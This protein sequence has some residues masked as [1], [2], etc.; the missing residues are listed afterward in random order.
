MEPFR[1]VGGPLDLTRTWSRVHVT[2][3]KRRQRY[4]DPRHE[5]YVHMDPAR[6]I[7]DQAKARLMAG[8]Q[9]IVERSQ[10]CLLLQARWRTATTD[11]SSCTSGQQEV[12]G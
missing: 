8:Q 4:P 12:E 3:G 10:L 7:L 11:G 9:L 6:S 2:V 5:Q 1:T